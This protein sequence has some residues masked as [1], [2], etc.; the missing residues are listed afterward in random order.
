[1]STYPGPDIAGIQQ[2]VPEI[3]VPRK[4]FIVTGAR[5]ALWYP[6]SGPPPRRGRKGWEQTTAGPPGL[7]PAVVPEWKGCEG[8]QPSPED[9]PRSHVDLD[10][11]NPHRRHR[12]VD[13]RLRSPHRS[14]LLQGGGGLAMMGDPAVAVTAAASGSPRVHSS[15][16]TTTRT[17][18]AGERTTCRAGGRRAPPAPAPPARERRRPGGGALHQGPAARGCG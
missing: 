10:R 16:S 5:C 14:W 18:P 2:V 12:C 7:V 3:G 1:M 8:P 17:R 9:R 13:G 4:S 15:Q 6:Q 11:P